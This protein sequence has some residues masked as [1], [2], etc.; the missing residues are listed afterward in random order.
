MGLHTSRRWEASCFRL[1]VQSVTASNINIVG[2]DSVSYW[3]TIA[4]NPSSLSFTGANLIF[5][6]P[7][8]S[9]TSGNRVTV[10]P[11]GLYSYGDATN[12]IYF[13]AQSAGIFVSVGARDVGFPSVNGRMAFGL[14]P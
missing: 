11:S 6:G 13:A 7:G 9:R 1:G 8:I 5:A 10:I 4:A 14:I 3:G 12:G 2:G